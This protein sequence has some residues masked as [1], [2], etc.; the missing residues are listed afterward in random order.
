MERSVAWSRPPVPAAGMACA[1]AAAQRAAI[2]ADDALLGDD[3]LGGHR[4]G[5]VGVEGGCCLADHFDED[6]RSPLDAVQG[7]PA[8]SLLPG[9]RR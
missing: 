5:A 1:W 6:C 3:A 4:C 7:K 8:V 2:G 9:Y